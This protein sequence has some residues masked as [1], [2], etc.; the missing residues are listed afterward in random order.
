LF[1]PL[2]FKLVDDLAL[3]QPGQ[4]EN[5]NLSFDASDIGPAIEY[6]FLTRSAGTALPALGTISR[7]ALSLTVTAASGA[8]PQ[9]LTD[10]SIRSLEAEVVRLPQSLAGNPH[11]SAFRRRF[12]DAAAVAGFDDL[13]AK[14]FTGAFGEIVA[15]VNDHSGDPGSAVVAYQRSAKQFR[16]VVADSGMGIL[17]SLRQNA[18]YAALRDHG[19]ALRMAMSTGE[20]RFGRGSG[21]GTGFDTVFRNIASFSGNIRFRS[22]DHS[23]EVA[24][25]SLTLASAHL[26]QRANFSGFFAF[27]SCVA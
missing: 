12:T 22:G 6:D 24:G 13:T 25:Q 14:G 16:F 1:V 5:A 8:H 7:S 10:T 15:N 3:A 18:A 17:T 20:T 23:L 21:R 9:V 11:W 27:I 19:E 4:L 2:D 26:R